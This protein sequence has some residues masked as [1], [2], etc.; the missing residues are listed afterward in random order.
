M[1]RFLRGLDSK[2]TAKI[3]Y[4]TGHLKKNVNWTSKW[5]NIPRTTGFSL[6]LIEDLALP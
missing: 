6:V 3:E 5:R 1:S 2:I 4:L